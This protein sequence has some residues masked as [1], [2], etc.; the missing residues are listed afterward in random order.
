MEDHLPGN[1]DNQ[2]T[3]P[4]I[5]EFTIA[6]QTLKFRKAK[7]MDVVTISKMTKEVESPQERALLMLA[8]FLVDDTKNE[9]QK[10]DFINN[11][12]INNVDDFISI[13][14]VLES[15]GI[16]SKKSTDTQSAE[17]KK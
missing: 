16:T 14:T 11:L 3:N 15:L 2:I 4:T 9:Q 8:M 17:K 6:G 13:N 7:L 1:P 12:E 5:R 10:K